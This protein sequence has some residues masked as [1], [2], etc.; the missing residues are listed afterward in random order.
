MNAP[1]QHS[2][3]LFRRTVKRESR[4]FRRCD[5]EGVRRIAAMR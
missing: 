1:S 5:A 3:V 4:I 2:F